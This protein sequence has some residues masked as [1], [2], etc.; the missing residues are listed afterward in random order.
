MTLWLDAFFR[1][2]PPSPME[3][4]MA[5]TYAPGLIVLSLFRRDAGGT[6][7]IDDRPAAGHRS[8]ACVGGVEDNDSTRAVIGDNAPPFDRLAPEIDA[9]SALKRVLN[10]AAMYRSM[11]GRFRS[12]QRDV[13]RRLASV[14]E[15]GEAAPGRNCWSTA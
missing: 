1:P 15:T 2:A 8:A 12:D 13:A 4:A 9:A 7:R 14:L 5:G 6:R 10:N 11:L 3:T